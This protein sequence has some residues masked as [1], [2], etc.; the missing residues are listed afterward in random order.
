[1]MAF[2]RGFDSAA[3]MVIDQAGIITDSFN[4]AKAADQSN[5]ENILVIQ[6]K[7]LGNEAKNA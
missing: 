5:A 7:D 3:L 1:M 4:F 6:S 2:K